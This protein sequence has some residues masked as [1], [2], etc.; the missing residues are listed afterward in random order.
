MQLLFEV[1]VSAVVISPAMAQ[2]LVY[3][4]EYYFTTTITAPPD[5]TITGCPTITAT[6]N[7]CRTCAYPMCLVLSTLTQGCSCPDTVAT[8][9]TSHPCDQRCGGIGCSTS[10]SIVSAPSCT[11]SSSI[12]TS[13]SKSDS[14]CASSGPLPPPP[15]PTPK[16]SN[17]T[18]SSVRT[19]PLPSTT[20]SIA[21]ANAA[22][23]LTP[24][25]LW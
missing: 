19:P 9:F 5:P 15:S 8:A 20:S 12:S 16:H 4:S 6:T 22:G 25:N 13:T 18:L 2:T 11:S 17:G 3:P 23:R 1:V 7:Q 14:V 21:I 10:W 24:F